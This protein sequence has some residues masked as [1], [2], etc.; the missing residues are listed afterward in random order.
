[1]GEPS[2]GDAHDDDGDHRDWRIHR[3]HQKGPKEGENEQR[4]E[5]T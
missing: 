4:Q 1:M 5:I 3:S 2:S